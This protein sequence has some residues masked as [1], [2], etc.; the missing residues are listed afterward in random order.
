MMTKTVISAIA[1]ASVTAILLTV[2]GAFGDTNVQT[3]NM[4]AGSSLGVT[5]PNGLT[6]SSVQD[7]TETVQCAEDTVAP[8][9]STTAVPVT[10]STTAPTPTTSTTE[11]TPT[12]STTQPPATTST[13]APP[14]TVACTSATNGNTSGKAYDYSGITNSNGFNTYV[15]NNMWGAKP[16][17]KQTIC[18]DPSN[19]TVTANMVPADG[20]SVQTY[21]DIQQLMDDYTGSPGHNS[22]NDG[23]NTTGTP[24]ANLNSLTSSYTLTDPPSGQG[25]W[26]AAYDIWLNDGEAH[27]EIMIWVDTS[28]ERLMNNGAT[29]INPGVE[30]DGNPTFTYM[31]YQGELPQLVVDGNQASGTI[32]ILSA[33]KY[34][35]SI[36]FMPTTAT[37]GQ[38]DFGWELC[39]TGGTT[40]TFRASG[41]TLKM[42]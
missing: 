14:T 40:Q 33:L 23:P 15:F 37:I 8:T 32:N 18:G 9:T 34:L 16:G 2:T 13:T 38:L 28:T 36:G 6:N 11:P 29:I 12:T 21:P 7:Q 3:F 26:E 31:N 22:W 19:V 24:I 25:D 30:T 39:N 41:Y 20:T 10:T 42:G 1:A 5:C 35:E 4:V 17:T 27:S